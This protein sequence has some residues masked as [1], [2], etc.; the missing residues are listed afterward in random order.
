MSIIYVLTVLVWIAIRHVALWFALVA[1]P[2]LLHKVERSVPS[3]TARTDSARPV[4]DSLEVLMLTTAGNYEQISRLLPHL[5]ADSKQIGRLPSVLPVDLAIDSFQIT[6]PFGNR[7]HPIRQHSRWHNGIDIRASL[8]IGVKATAAGR[9]KRVGYDKKLGAYVYIQH[10]FGFETMYGHLSAYCVKQGETVER[11]QEIGRVGATGLSTGP[12]LHY[13][14]KKNGSAIDP[15]H[16]CFLLRQRLRLYQEKSKT[17]GAS[18]SDSAG[19][20]AN[21]LFSSG[22]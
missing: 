1:G 10:A 21:N 15:L 3:T 16:F 12:H 18:V 8:G 13:I 17:S 4:R 14:I 2:G 22:K 7:I 11:N 19:L 20:G 9:V 5:S 6:S